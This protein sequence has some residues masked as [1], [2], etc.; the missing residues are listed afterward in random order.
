LGL[1]TIG[2]VQFTVRHVVM[3]VALL[4][5]RSV[6]MTLIAALLCGC[7]AGET[8]QLRPAI[9]SVS[10]VELRGGSSLIE[11][12]DS[13]RVSTLV[14]ELNVLRAQPWK[15]W[16]G[17]DG[18]TVDVTFFSG[19]QRVL[20]LHVYKTAVLEQALVGSKLPMFET[21]A[22]VS[23]LPAMYRLIA[24]HRLAETCNW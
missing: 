3:G 21:S 11:V 2:A 12:N 18:C 8:S 5:R 17:K 13:E 23:E 20:Y 6:R 7:T 19:T 24:D 22:G 16:V 1:A 15:E 14:Q 4:Y 9:G 10:K